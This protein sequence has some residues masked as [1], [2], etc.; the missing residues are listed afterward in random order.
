MVADEREAALQGLE[1]LKVFLDQAAGRI[2]VFVGRRACLSEKLFDSPE[3]Q[4]AIILAVLIGWK[5]A[6][7]D[8]SSNETN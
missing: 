4:K 8:V 6:D 3:R 5:A 7:I 1:S 2:S